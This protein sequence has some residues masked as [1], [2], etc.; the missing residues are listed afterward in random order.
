M[1]EVIILAAG[2]G[3]RMYSDKPKVLHEVAGKPML[4][5]VLE[6]CHELG[7][8]KL[9]VVYGFAGDLLRERISDGKINWVLQEEQKGTG[10][11]IDVA[12]PHVSDES[13]VLV[14]YG[15]VPL[16]S[17]RSL[18]A[19][20]ETAGSNAV[21]LMTAYLDDAGAYGRIIRDD[22]KN[23]RAIIEYQDADPDQRLINE[24]NTGFLC[25]PAARL[26]QWVES[27]ES[28]N[29]QGEYY[30]TDIFA[31]A[32]AEGVAVETCEPIDHEEILGINNRLDLAS[33][34]RAYQHR[35]VREL[36]ERGLSVADPSR[37]DIR[38]ALR[39]GRDCHVDINV[40]FEGEVALGDRVRIGPNCVL[41]N[42]RIED[43]VEIKSNCV[44]EE[45][46]I[47]ELAIVGPF[48]RIR[49]QSE[50]AAFAHIGNFVEIK[51]STIGNGSK[52]NHLSYIGDSEIGKDVNVG[53]GVITCNYDG[54]NKHQTVIGDNAF[55]G[56][57][58]QLVAPVEV[59]EGATIGAG[60]TIVED[61]PAG[62]LTLSRSKQ[63]TRKGWRR[64]QKGDQKKSPR[65]G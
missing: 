42:V 51:K 26:R 28:D 65:K 19:L 30:L 4:E 27:I 56:S 6:T 58:C 8:D 24:I 21:G 18:R 40:I 62:E 57:D 17:S 9:H 34:E 14:L 20:L 29:A 63:V 15:D 7:A 10:H 43:D 13:T 39:H 61:A 64:P 25:A 23:F 45:S 49:P 35:R 12:M 16:I 47:G 37:V 1:L 44:I 55:I 11:A 48:S 59:G 38:G 46:R 36:M 5:H 60:S 53:A 32:V 41:K 22:N 33:V 31:M 50:I 3:T 2:K 52:V 54:A